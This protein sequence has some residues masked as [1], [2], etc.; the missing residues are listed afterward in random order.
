MEI[1]GDCDGVD[2]IGG[3]TVRKK[4]VFEVSFR[5]CCCEGSDHSDTPFPQFVGLWSKK[6]I[7]LRLSYQT[8]VG[9]S[10][11]VW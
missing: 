11:A 9:Y 4:S 3:R 5:F 6:R 10:G 7:A 8:C 1:T 2:Y